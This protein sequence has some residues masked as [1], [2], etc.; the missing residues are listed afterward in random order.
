MRQR[1]IS[2][3]VKEEL[4]WKVIRNSTYGGPYAH[5]MLWL[6]VVLT[7]S[8]YQNHPELCVSVVVSMVSLIVLRM[9]AF[10][11]FR[12]NPERSFKTAVAFTRITS[13][14]FGLTWGAAAIYIFKYYG[15]SLPTFFVIAAIVG[16]GAG[17]ISEFAYDFKQV[18][19]FTTLSV[20]PWTV[21]CFMNSNRAGF[22]TMGFFG[23]FLMIFFVFTE[24]KSQIVLYEALENREV[25]KDQR[26]Q[27]KNVIEAIP[28]FV[29]WTDEQGACAGVNMRLAQA[30]GR[31]IE[32]FIAGKVKPFN[33]DQS[34]PERFSH[35]SR[36]HLAHDLFETQL[37][38]GK[39]LRWCLVTMTKFKTVIGHQILVIV[40]DIEEQKRAEAELEIAKQKAHESSR[41]AALG[42]MAGGVAHEINNPLA[43]ISGTVSALRAREIGNSKDAP[44]FQKGFDKIE[45]IVFRIAKIVKGLQTVARD[46]EKDP[47]ENIAIGTLLQDTIE[48]CQSRM[49]HEGI[50]IRLGAIPA[51]LTARCRPTQIGQVVLSLMNN[52]RDAIL[53]LPEKWIQITAE[54]KGTA[55]EISITD[56]GNG[57]PGEIRD[58]LMIPFFTT[59]EIGQGT[60]LGLSVSKAILEDHDGSL[61]LDTTQKH[62]C[63]IMRLPRGVAQIQDYPVAA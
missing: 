13:G 54:S 18:V 12:R 49:K 37:P 39:S 6:G 36:S 2:K 38:V 34:I 19:I 23:I 8:F 31:K 14:L 5:I 29:Y 28:G 42:T 24:R 21:Y 15:F 7:G 52:S 47:F 46:G 62:T 63:F 45:T 35:F 61:T 16:I 11:L 59:K 4:G 44:A 43:I 48:L 58:K 32:E 9:I 50:D 1:R 26:D 22:M 56:S 33:F 30:H 10:P 57:I 60:G 17:T 51:H 20:L 53:H 27:F 55:I 25:I 3:Q 40:L 41:L